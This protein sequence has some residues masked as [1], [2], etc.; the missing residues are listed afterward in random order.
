[1]KNITHFI[2]GFAARLLNILLTFLHRFLFDAGSATLRNTV[3]AHSMNSLGSTKG[4]NRVFIEYPKNRSA[5]LPDRD[6]YPDIP[7]NPV[8]VNINAYT[9]GPDPP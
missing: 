6:I 4:K 5:A 8:A 3:V 7:A 2:P 1:M 9:T